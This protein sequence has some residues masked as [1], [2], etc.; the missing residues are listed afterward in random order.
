MQSSP[1]PHS[2]GAGNGIIG[3]WTTRS[4]ARPGAVAF[5]E[6]GSPAPN[7]HALFGPGSTG[8]G[9]Y[10]HSCAGAQAGKVTGSH[11]GTRISVVT[12]GPGPCAVPPTM[13]QGAGR[14][15]L[16]GV[17]SMRYFTSKLAVSVVA[18]NAWTTLLLC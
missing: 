1:T 16:P 18:D 7:A 9:E 2:G 6:G 8:G 12:P 11:A 15:A 14:G 13:A 5:V 17:V 4:G 3:Q 10:T